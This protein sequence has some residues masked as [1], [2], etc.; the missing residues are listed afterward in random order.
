MKKAKKFQFVLCLVLC[1]MFLTGCFPK[2][3]VSNG[4]VQISG[5]FLDGTTYNPKEYADKVVILDFWATWC[6]P[7]RR[8]I[9]STIAPLYAMY[10][11][12]GLEIIGISCD[13]DAETVLAYTQQNGIEWKQMLESE[14]TTPSGRSLAE[15]YGVKY[16]PF[17]ILIGRNGKIVAMNL[18]GK[19]L[20]V[21]VKAEI[22]K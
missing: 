5:T 1:C 15:H 20:E 9:A 14:A 10:H 19:E 8:E 16:I 12:S 18:H 6:P 11:E 17:P 4:K 2:T 3:R 7:C 21:M 13:Q 22:M